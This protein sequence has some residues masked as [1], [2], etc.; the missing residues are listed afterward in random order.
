M[1][2]NTEHIYSRKIL[3]SHSIKLTVKLV[4]VGALV[5]GVEGAIERVH[6]DH[7]VVGHD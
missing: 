7:G 3:N 2:C 4:D 6:G 5:E 1:T